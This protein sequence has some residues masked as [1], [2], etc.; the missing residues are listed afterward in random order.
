MKLLRTLILRPLRRDL[1]RTA[2]TMLS[3]ALGVAVVVAIDL[4]GDAATGSFRSSMQTLA[5]KTDLEI[6]ANGGI[7]ERWI[8]TLAGLPYNA[9]FAP[10]I[11]SQAVIPG[12]GSV[13]LYG[14]DL[15]ASGAGR[16]PERRA[17]SPDGILVSKA[18]ANRLPSGSFTVNL[19]GRS[20]T[21]SISQTL[22]ST[23]EFLVLDIADAQRALDRYGKLD[24]I[25]VTVSPTEDFS[26]VEAAIRQTLPP[27]YL[28][29]KPGARSAENQRMLRAFRWNLRVL[30][31]ISLVVGAFLIYNT[32]SVSVVRR[33][34][35][36]GILRALG[37]ARSTVLGLFLAEAALFGFAGATLGVLLGR[38]LAGGTVHLIADTVNA[39]YTSSRPTPVELTAGE[40]GIGIVTGLLVALAGASTRRAKPWTL[41]HISHAPRRARAPRPAAL[42]PPSGLG[43][44]LAA[45][46]GAASEAAPVVGYPW[47]GTPPHSSPSAQPPWPRPP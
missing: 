42:G 23:A 39:L 35:E 5:G 32:I 44:L 16:G 28:I 20:K 17:A 10:L 14:V 21:F 6:L 2:L 37:A 40:A 8:A 31:Y 27:S 11:A 9:T 30:S 38:L 3:V 47:V 33:R 43:A 22:D 45:L 4:S 18:L 24:R 41:P 19:A 1:L 26:R 29:E 34:A 36:I 13:P 15:V 7:D 25:D 46:A 12:I